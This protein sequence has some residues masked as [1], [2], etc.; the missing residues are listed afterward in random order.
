MTPQAKDLHGFF[1]QTEAIMEEQPTSPFDLSLQAT[2]PLSIVIPN[3]VQIVTMLVSG[4]IRCDRPAAVGLRVNELPS[5]YN[6][7]T[8]QNIGGAFVLGNASCA[9]DFFARFDLVTRYGVT[10]SISGTST[11]TNDTGHSVNYD[12]Q[13][14]LQI[15]DKVK[16]ISIVSLGDNATLEG[17][18]YS[19]ERH[20]E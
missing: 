9:T 13:G 4:R 6:S 10:K 15:A 5:G 2:R 7:N 16:S 18:W 8:N 20:Q 1:I 19:V 14:F 12:I 17:I 11:F 3:A